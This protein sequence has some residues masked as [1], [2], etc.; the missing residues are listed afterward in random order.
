MKKNA[1]FVVKQQLRALPLFGPY[2]QDCIAVTRKS[3]SDDF[4]QKI[5]HGELESLERKEYS[6]F[7]RPII[8]DELVN[9]SIF[10][11]FE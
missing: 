9:K 6:V 8:F 3:P 11:I 4:K 10:A 5:T 7:Q 1:I 2:V